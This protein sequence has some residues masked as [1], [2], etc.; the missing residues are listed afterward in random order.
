MSMH[1]RLYIYRGV[2]W[3]NTTRLVNGKNVLGCVA[4]KNNRTDFMHNHND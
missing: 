2:I 3:G 1:G 4:Y